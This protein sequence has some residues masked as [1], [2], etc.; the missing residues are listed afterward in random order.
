M[1]RAATSCC[2]ETAWKQLDE[3]TVT[4]DGTE[5]GVIDEVSSNEDDSS[6]SEE[7]NASSCPLDAGEHEDLPHD[8][9]RAWEPGENRSANEGINATSQ[10]EDQFDEVGPAQWLE[11]L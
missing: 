3:Q 5:N 8:K 10:P 1:A 6:I 9:H 7:V 4:D 11:V 2:R